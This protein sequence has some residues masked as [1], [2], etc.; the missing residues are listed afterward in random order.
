MQR[1]AA[2]KVPFA[3]KRVNKVQNNRTMEES[4]VIAKKIIE[5]KPTK[6]ITIFIDMKD[7]ERCLK[8]RMR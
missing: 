8:V 3:L 6:A 5:K 2:S 7:I 4:E 1:Q